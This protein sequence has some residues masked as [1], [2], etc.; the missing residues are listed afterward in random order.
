MHDLPRGLDQYFELRAPKNEPVKSDS[1]KKV[2]KVDQREMKKSIERIERAVS[3]RDEE[4][5]KLQI[6]MDGAATDFTRL[7]A[8]HGEIERL[9]GEKEALEQEWLTLLAQL[10]G[11][12][13][14]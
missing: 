14:K 12:E 7:A 13:N 4:L 2:A 3:R 10:E 6:E 9:Q 1:I 11:V 5:Q 8:I